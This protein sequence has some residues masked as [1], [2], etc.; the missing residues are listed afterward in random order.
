MEEWCRQSLFWHKC[1]HILIILSLK[2]HFT[3]LKAILKEII[4]RTCD[5]NK[6]C[7]KAI[8][9]RRTLPRV[10]YRT[11]IRFCEYWENGSKFDRNNIGN[12]GV[13]CYPT[14]ESTHLSQA[15]NCYIRLP[16]RCQHHRC[17]ESYYFFLYSL[18]L[19]L[20]RARALYICVLFFFPA[21]YVYTAA[22]IY[23]SWTFPPFRRP[24]R[25]PIS[26]LEHL[27]SLHPAT[28]AKL[29]YFAQNFW[30]LIVKLFLLED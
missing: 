16:F 28:D 9:Y 11:T 20:S 18:S 13:T 26:V 3:L 22:V 7:K 12:T 19:S 17:S 25:R 29:K 10:A 15:M 4:L 23:R 5:C 27:I 1:K 2:G 24:S 14:R 8:R 6:L 30:T 21:S